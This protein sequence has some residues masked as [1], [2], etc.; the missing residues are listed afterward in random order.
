M[1][2]LYFKS[3]SA[4]MIPIKVPGTSYHELRISSVVFSNTLE[5]MTALFSPCGAISFSTK[6]PHQPQAEARCGRWKG[7]M[8]ATRPNNDRGNDKHDPNP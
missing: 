3:Q 2:L 8:E 1:E 6:R 4:D 7:E 5:P